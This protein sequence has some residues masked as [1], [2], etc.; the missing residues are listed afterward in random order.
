MGE[1]KST[2]DLV[3]ERTKNLAMSESEKEKQR[4]TELKKR[5]TGLIQKVDDQAIKLSEFDE[6]LEELQNKFGPDT[7]AHILEMVLDGVGLNHDS[8]RRLDLLADHFKLDISSV[9]TVL[10]Q[11]RLSVED[12]K[13]RH[14]EVLKSALSNNFKIS[15][16]AVIPN[17]ETDPDWQQKRQVVAERFQD[18]LALEKQRMIAQ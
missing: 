14:I 4:Q 2:L 16:T 15:G 9:S 10:D 11:Y 5:L 3:M 8:T 18:Q 13:N 6:Q 12:L 1:I 17:I 7:A